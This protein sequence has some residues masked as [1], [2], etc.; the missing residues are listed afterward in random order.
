[1]SSQ[2]YQLE[3]GCRGRRFSTFTKIGYILIAVH[4]NYNNN[5]NNTNSNN[6]NNGEQQNNAL[7]YGLQSA[8]I[9]S[10]VLSA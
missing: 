3:T 8:G 10:L 6:N 5:S 7:H 2:T 4:N 9:A 1:M